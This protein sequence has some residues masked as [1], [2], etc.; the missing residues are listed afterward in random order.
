MRTSTIILID[1]FLLVSLKTTFAQYLSPKFIFSI[2]N[3]IGGFD[4]ATFGEDDT[5]ICGVPDSNGDIANPCPS[6]APPKMVDKDNS[7]LYP[8]DSEFGFEVVDFL[9]AVAKDKS[10][11]GYVADYQEGFAGN[12]MD[13]PDIIGLKVANAATD[14][15]KV[16]P[17]LGTWCQG[18]T[19]TAVKCST[20]HY[21]VMEH[22]LSCHETI[23]YLYADPVTGTQSVQTLPDGRSFDCSDA[24]LDNDVKVLVGG[25]P[26]VT[27]DTGVSDPDDPAFMNPNDDTDV[28]DD[29][30]LSSDYSLT[31]KDDGKALYRWGSLIKRPNDIRIK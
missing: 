10:R 29:I 4:G 9:G 5:I 18:L 15:Y 13:G 26:G 1:W 19:S 6:E 25:V 20:E 7:V 3:I 31:L 14:T 11:D 24:E 12:V 23:P 2:D 21:S 16:G 8:I 22:V 17:H 28:L 27:Y 30:A